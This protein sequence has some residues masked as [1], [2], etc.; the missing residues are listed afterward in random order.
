MIR[1]VISILGLL[2][3]GC[4]KQRQSIQSRPDST[5]IVETVESFDSRLESATIPDFLLEDKVDID[6]VLKT[7]HNDYQASFD[8][9]TLSICCHDLLDITSNLP[10][11][12]FQRTT[13]DYKD[14]EKVKIVEV[15]SRDDSFYKMFYNSHPDVQ[16]TD[17]VCGQ[18][19]NEGIVFDQ[20]VRIGM[21][22]HELLIKIFH[23][24]KTLDRVDKLEIYEN[25]MGEAWTIYVFRNDTLSEIEFDSNCDWIERKVRK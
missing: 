9:G 24:S 5:D 21:P 3:F 8:G 14:D 16:K 23:P 7:R 25:E 12:S 4:A 17:L 11:K 2:A 6:S 20:G 15:Y 1:K 22:K 19:R 10:S 13:E 18:I